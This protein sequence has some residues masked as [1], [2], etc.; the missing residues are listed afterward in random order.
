ME[1]GFLDSGGSLLTDTYNSIAIQTYH[2]AWTHTGT[3]DV[4]EN[5]DTD[6]FHLSNTW[7][8]ADTSLGQTAEVFFYD[9]LNTDKAQ[10]IHWISTAADTNPWFIT[11]RGFGTQDTTTAKHGLRFNVSG[12][13]CTA[14][15]HYAVYGYKL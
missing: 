6:G 8:Q 10:M 7:Q 4:F 9:P 14:A 3:Q 5:Q 11:D 1:L 2:N 12:G 13:T 15:G